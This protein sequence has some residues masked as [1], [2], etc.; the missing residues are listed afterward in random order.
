MY[1]LRFSAMAAG[2]LALAGLACPAQATFFSFASDMNSN[3]YTFGGT[4]GTAGAFS[5]TDFSRPNTFTLHIDDNNGPLPTLQIPVEFR[6]AI[7]A[8]TGLSTNIAGNLWIHSYRV[9]GTFGFYNAAG[10]ALLTATVGPTNPAVLTVPGSQ[11][12]WSSTGAVLGS[13]TYANIVYTASPQL[14]AAMG[15]AAVATQY[16]IAAGS[17]TVPSDF[18]FDLSVINAG[19]IG[20]VVS[21]DPTTKA[22]ISAWRSESSYS[23]SAQGFVPSPGAA[24]CSEPPGSSRSSVAAA[25]NCSPPVLDVARSLPGR[26]RV[27]ALHPS[28]LHLNRHRRSPPGQRY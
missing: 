17:A 28:R 3:A 12:T 25:T 19:A 15:G 13:D 16:G 22:P 21:I 5:L 24:H 6:A 7:T 8:N 20:Q 1:S 27:G 14:V 2:A 18:A 26:I 10:I 9:T 23:G 11:T 4:A